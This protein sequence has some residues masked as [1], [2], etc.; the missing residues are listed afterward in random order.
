MWFQINYKEC[1]LR[2]NA[3]VFGNAKSFRLTIRNVNFIEYLEKNQNDNCFR[4]TIRN[5]NLL[6]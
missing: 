2:C 3:Q 4:L 6:L 5:V 1:K